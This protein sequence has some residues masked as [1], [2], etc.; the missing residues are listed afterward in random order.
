MNRVEIA[1]NL[2]PVQYG[3]RLETSSYQERLVPYLGQTVLYYQ[4][5][6]GKTVDA[7]RVVPDGCMDVLICCDPKRPH[8]LICGTILQGESIPFHAGATYFGVR[9]TPLQ[10]LHLSPT[11]F[12]ELIDRQLHLGD[13]V[14][15]V[16]SL[17]DDIAEK[18]S[19]SQR[20]AHFERFLLPK[21]LSNDQPYGWLPY[22]LQQ[23]YQSK[24][25]VSVDQL[26]DDIG[27]STRYIRKKFVETLGLSPKQ[28]SRIT[29]FQNTLSSMMNRTTT[30]GNI[31]SEHGYYDQAHF[32][33]DFK[34]FSLF[35]PM[36]IIMMMQTSP[37]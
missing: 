25:N 34:H 24:G 12:R 13:V 15:G 30:S 11:P 6:M 5:V 10:S 14:H 17:C 4:Y 33:K 2:P 32:I 36:Q 28:Y 22:C 1:A 37:F 8:S 18:A 9:L 7:I 21:L 16:S 20:I 27:F 19:F 35:T 26:A 31:A 23:I 29:R 3:F